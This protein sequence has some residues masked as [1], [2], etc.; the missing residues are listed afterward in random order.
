MAE[1]DDLQTYA[2][3]I[4]QDVIARADAAEDGARK[5]AMA[6]AGAFGRD[7]P[8]LLIEPQS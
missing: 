8:A 5:P 6:G 4:L 1:I 2:V 3:N 7:Q